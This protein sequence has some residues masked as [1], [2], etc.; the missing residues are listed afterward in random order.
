MQANKHHR[1]YLQRDGQSFAAEVLE[2]DCDSDAMEKAK[3]LLGSSMTF[4]TTEVWQ[5]S[6][7]VGIVERSSDKSGKIAEEP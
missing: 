7:R 6:R 4:H 3:G 5:G 2:C 1:F